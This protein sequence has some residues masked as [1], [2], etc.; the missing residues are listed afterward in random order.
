MNEKITTLVIKVGGA[1]MQAD[2]QALALLK[3]IG[4]LQQDI[5]VVLVHGGGPMVEELMQALHLT[6]SKINGLRVT[7]K[8]HMPYITGALAGTANKQFAPWQSNQA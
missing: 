5:K 2:Q 1:F 4:Q 8:E 7:P 6:S 3:V